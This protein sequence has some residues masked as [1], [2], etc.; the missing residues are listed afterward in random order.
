M[1]FVTDVG[2]YAKQKHARRRLYIENGQCLK[3]SSAWYYSSFLCRSD[4]PDLVAGLI[5]S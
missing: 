1:L 4:S 3:E 5:N 2:S